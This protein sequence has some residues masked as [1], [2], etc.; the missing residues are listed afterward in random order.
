M[1]TATGLV[2]CVFLVVV[3]TTDW[4]VDCARSHGLPN[5][6]YDWCVKDAHH[7]CSF[8]KTVQQGET[9]LELLAT[10]QSATRLEILESPRVQ[11][12]RDTTLL[13]PLVSPHGTTPLKPSARAWV[14]TSYYCEHIFLKGAKNQHPKFDREQGCRSG[15]HNATNFLGG[16]FPRSTG[17]KIEESILYQDNKSTMLLRKNVKIPAVQEWNTPM[18]YIISWMIV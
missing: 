3:T 8:P 9:R 4:F 12:L 16:I 7:W 5:P 1:P 6:G 15:W 13:K 10:S 18:W 11:T 14:L 17:Y 2:R